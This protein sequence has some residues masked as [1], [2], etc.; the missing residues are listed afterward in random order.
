MNPADNNIYLLQTEWN[1]QGSSYATEINAQ[2]AFVEEHGLHNWKGQEPADSRSELAL[3]VL[4]LLKKANREGTI[5]NFRASYPPAHAPFLNIIQE[6]GQNIENLC[7]INDN[8]IAFIIGSAYEKR[9]AYVLTNRNIEKLSDS[10]QAIGR[11]HQNNIYAIAKTNSITTHKN[12]EGRRI[13]EFKLP[14]VATL[15]ISQLIPFNDGLSVLLI[16]SE[17]IYLLTTSGHT[18]IHPV[19]DPQDQ[20]WSSYIDM[21]HAALSYDNDLIAVGDQTSA[22]RLLNRFGHHLAT[23]APQSSFPH[24]ALFSKDGQKILLNSCHL[25]DGVTISVPTASF[26]NLYPGLTSQTIIDKNCRV[27]A[28]VATSELYIFGDAAGHIQ[29]FDQEGK[30][31][32]HYFVGSTITSMTLSEDEK[33][34]WVASCSGMIHKLK[35]NEGQRDNHTIGNGKHYEEFRVIFWKNEPQPL[36]W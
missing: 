2:L 5:D 18:L 32:W 17:G 35:L 14:P 27:Y 9:R 30:K 22:H 3:E 4:S 24:Y 20:E 25:Y 21:E 7:Y 6:Q 31:C 29:A 12:W 11:S 28:A 34:L 36:V 33:T 13:A 1:I 23:I 8:T 26:T 16:S 10:I 19:P 15:P